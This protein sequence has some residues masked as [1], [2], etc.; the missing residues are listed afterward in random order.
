MKVLL[1]I[2]GLCLVGVAAISFSDTDLGSS[3]NPNSKL[4]PDPIKPPHNGESAVKTLHCGNYKI[5]NTIV[6]RNSASLSE[7]LP[8]VEHNEELSSMTPQLRR[9]CAVPQIVKP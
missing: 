7:R 2:I 3:T 9:P 8:N 4:D 1:L 6:Q 5:E